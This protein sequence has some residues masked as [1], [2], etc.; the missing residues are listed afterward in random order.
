MTTAHPTPPDHLRS[1]AGLDAAQPSA[2]PTR[3]GREHLLEAAGELVA[4]VEPDRKAG[5]KRFLDAA[6]E[7]GLDLSNFWGVFD[8]HGRVRHVALAAPGSGRTHMCFTSQVKSDADANGLASAL[9]AACKALATPGLAQALLDDASPLSLAFERAG[10]RRLATLGY[11][12]RRSPRVRKQAHAPAGSD[13]AFADLPEGVTVEQWREGMDDEFML[14]L[15]RSYADTL[16]CPELCGLR[17]TADVL[18]SHK[19][20]GEFHP[21]LWTLVRDR[22]EP[23]GAML[24]SPHSQHTHIELVYLGIA[25]S[26]RG[27]GLAKLLLE[28]GLRALQKRPERVVTCAVDQRNEPAKRLYRN[29]GFEQFAERVAYIRPVG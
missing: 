10:F 13:A 24:F 18:A 21:A 16:D 12:R 14:A 26:L 19:A 9:D 4:E 1:L 25:P 2:V 5:G 11:L 28:H 20:A 8:A 17:E 23:A 27:K 3:I 7:H 6:R 29:A 15:D 22:G